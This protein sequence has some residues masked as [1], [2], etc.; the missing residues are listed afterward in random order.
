M[1]IML[2][3]FS[4]SR[5]CWN[6]PEYLFR[7]CDVHVL[8]HHLPQNFRVRHRHRAQNRLRTKTRLVGPIIKMQIWP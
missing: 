2:N 6:S 1:F 7:E 3:I 5:Y 8:I 4:N